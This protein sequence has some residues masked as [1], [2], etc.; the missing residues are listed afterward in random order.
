MRYRYTLDNSA[1]AAR[2][3]HERVSRQPASVDGR[4]RAAVGTWPALMGVCGAAV[5][6]FFGARLI[7]VAPPGPSQKG[8]IVSVSELRMREK[9]CFVFCDFFPGGGGEGREA[10]TLETFTQWKLFPP[11]GCGPECSSNRKPVKL[12][13]PWSVKPSTFITSNTEH[14]ERGIPACLFGVLVLFD[15]HRECARTYA[16]ATVSCQTVPE[17]QFVPYCTNTV[18]R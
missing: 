7:M 15:V 6:F 14:N 16:C 5:F 8:E 4:V 9:V 2:R 13:W 10:Y 12:P 17:R 11:A 1:M 3:K 18:N